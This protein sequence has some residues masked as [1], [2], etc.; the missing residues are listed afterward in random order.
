MN[1]YILVLLASVAIAAITVVS[2]CSKKEAPE[3]RIIAPAFVKVGNTGSMQPMYKGGETVLVMQKD[4]EQLEVGMVVIVW[5]EGRE[6]NVIHQII[7]K[8]RA[9]NG[10]L[11]YITKGINNLTRDNHV[12]VA[13]NFVGYVIPPAK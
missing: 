3:K 7:A 12:L 9:A 4:F 13:S 1:R 6:L 8:G 2:S 11:Y 5:W 10:E